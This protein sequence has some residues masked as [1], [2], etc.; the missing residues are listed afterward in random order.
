MWREL[1]GRKFLGLKFRRQHVAA[2]YI[3]DFY[4]H[5]L[6]L[7]IEIDGPVHDDEERMVYDK[8]R[9]HNL[10]NFDINFFRVTS[11]EV[12]QNIAQVLKK[13]D[14]FIKKFFP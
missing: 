1:R 8:E 10:E 4:C 6:K 7:A 2:G 13:L 9:Q 14:L 11:A 3:L 5:E 12:E